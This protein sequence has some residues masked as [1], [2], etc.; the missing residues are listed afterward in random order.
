MAPQMGQR[1]V[2]SGSLRR[3]AIAA[4]AKT[5]KNNPRKNQAS[6]LRLFRY[7]ITADSIAQAS[8]K[9]MTNVSTNDP[10]SCKLE[11]PSARGD[12]RGPRCCSWATKPPH[13]E[14]N[15]QSWKNPERTT[16]VSCALS[17]GQAV[18][19]SRRIDCTSSVE[20]QTRHGS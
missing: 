8:Q 6:T 10:S 18:S 11:L 3:M 4:R 5:P 17:G 12:Y 14:S 1:Q 20:A 9:T 16:S 19:V 13:V 15:E 7:A 2:S